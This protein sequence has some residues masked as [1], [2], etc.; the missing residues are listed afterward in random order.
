[1]LKHF[2]DVKDKEIL[3]IGCGTGIIGLHGLMK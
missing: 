1:M 2:P 3:D